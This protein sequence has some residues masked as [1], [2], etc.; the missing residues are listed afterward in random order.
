M[1]ISRICLYGTDIL[2]LAEPLAVLEKYYLFIF[3]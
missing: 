1:D 2:G 3:V